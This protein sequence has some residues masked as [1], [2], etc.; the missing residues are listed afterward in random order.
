[1]RILLNKC[2]GGIGLSEKFVE[3]YP[4][5]TQSVS[6]EDRVDP[7]LL[8]AIETFGITHAAGNYA[9][10]HIAEIP[11]EA[12]DWEIQEY[13]GYETVVWVLDGKLHHS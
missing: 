10:L 13:D 2:Y 7:E 3:A 5:F 11:D 6:E 4:K 8:E 9:L 1:M 12:T